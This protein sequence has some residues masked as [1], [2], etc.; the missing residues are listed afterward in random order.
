MTAW[1]LDSELSTC[2]ESF[3]QKAFFKV[4]VVNPNDSSLRGSI[5]YHKT[6]E[7]E[8]KEV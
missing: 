7:G 8:A 1:F 5:S 3:H 6:G 4:R 2:W